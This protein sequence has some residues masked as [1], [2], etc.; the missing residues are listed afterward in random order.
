[1]PLALVT[2]AS[3]LLWRQP[4]TP[5]EPAAAHVDPVPAEQPER[6][7]PLFQP[8]A[9]SP[10]PTHRRIPGFSLPAA[11]PEPPPVLREVPGTYAVWMDEDERTVLYAKPWPYQG[12]PSDDRTLSTTW[13]IEG[14]LFGASRRDL[15]GNWIFRRCK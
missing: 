13:L 1:M 14:Q 15:H 12:C 4:K 8:L 6:L 11:V 9:P 3:Q 5:V 2:R 7:A 10:P